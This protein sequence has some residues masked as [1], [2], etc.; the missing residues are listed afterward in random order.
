MAAQAWAT[1]SAS[2]S[3]RPAASGSVADSAKAEGVH[4][5]ELNTWY[6]NEHAQSAFAKLGFSVKNVRFCRQARS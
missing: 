1:K 3:A 5:V 4:E 2:T 6:F